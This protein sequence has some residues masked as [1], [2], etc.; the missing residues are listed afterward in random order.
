MK[1]FSTYILL[2][3]SLMA[4][5]VV[6]NEFPGRSQFPE[7][8]V[9]ELE[10]LYKS[11]ENMIIIDTRTDFEY[12]VIHIKDSFHVNFEADAYIDRLKEIRKN[13]RRKMVFYCNG[14]TCIKAFRA[15]DAA[16]K[17]GIRN[18][19]TFDAGVFTWARSYPDEAVL[20][21]KSPVD[22][23]KLLSREALMS[24][25]LDADSFAEKVGS[26]SLVLDVRDESQR[27]ATQLYPLHQRNITLD[28]PK[29]SDS[30]KTAAT[31]GKTVLIYDYTGQQVRW[32]QYLMESLEV[33]DYYFLKGGFRGFMNI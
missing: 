19:V 6:A 16:T 25:L 7:Q 17:A 13:D 12:D 3:L 1:K 2:L 18:T 14:L 27:E 29:L 11:R 15:H 31:Q 22:P 8:A 33:R 30:I 28:D 4:Q 10:D 5:S 23:N 9:I 24:R 21:G 32:V 26:N 20:M